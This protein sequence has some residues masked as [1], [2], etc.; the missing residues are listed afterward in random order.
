MENIEKIVTLYESYQYELEKTGDN[1]AVFSLG[2]GIYPGVDILISENISSE[3]YNT[4]RKEYSEAGYATNKVIF[5]SLENLEISLFTQFFKPKYSRERLLSHYKEYT[6][7]VMKP[8]QTKEDTP[9]YKY[10]EV[11]YNYEEN[12]IWAVKR[13][14]QKA[15]QR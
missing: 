2:A 14:L 1:F 8:Y 3:E 12:F 5:H 15:V 4:I 11:S 9:E 10:I 6:N 13:N 7:G